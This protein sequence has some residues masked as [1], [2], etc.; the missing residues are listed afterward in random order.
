MSITKPQGYKIASV[1][2]PVL[3]DVKL[4]DHNHLNQIRKC[5]H[6]ATLDFDNVPVW[7]TVT[8]GTFS[9]W[10][11]GLKGKKINHIITVFAT[12]GRQIS[13]FE[14]TAEGWSAYKKRAEKENL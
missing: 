14:F 6:G 11:R 5:V 4:T 3:E 13:R 1:E 2:G 12:D 8:R 7:V 10:T 9:P